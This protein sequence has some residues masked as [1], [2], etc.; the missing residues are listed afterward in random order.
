MSEVQVKLDRE[1]KPVRQYKGVQITEDTGLNYV[2]VYFPNGDQKTMG[3]IKRDPSE[4]NWT[5]C[6][7]APQAVFDAIQKAI[8]DERGGS[9]DSPYILTTFDDKE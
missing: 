3:Y 7:E 1:F 6:H 9:A 4:V 5:P 8:N 2:D